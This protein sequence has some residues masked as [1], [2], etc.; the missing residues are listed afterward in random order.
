MNENPQ[1]DKLSNK[2][3]GFTLVEVIIVIAIVG[4]LSALIIPNVYDYIE[5][6]RNRADVSAA[7]SSA[8]Q[9]SLNVPLTRIK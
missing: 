3:K 4:V 5:L 1:N 8:K 6:S 7:R 2:L 9:Y